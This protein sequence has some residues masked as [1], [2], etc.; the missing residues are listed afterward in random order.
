MNWKD[1]M[2]L[3]LVV[4]TLSSPVADAFQYLKQT[5]NDFINCKPTIQFIRIIDDI[6]DS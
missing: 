2:K 1:S 5:S 6:F 4:Q 3:K